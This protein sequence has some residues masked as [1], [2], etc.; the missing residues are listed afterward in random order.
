MR[1][2]Y[3]LCVTVICLLLTGIFALAENA[4]DK[5]HLDL[6]SVVSE[7][8]MLVTQFV[9]T[10]P[11]TARVELKRKG[12]RSEITVSPASNSPDGKATATLT[13]CAVVSHTGGDWETHLF[14]ITTETGH[15]GGPGSG[16]INRKTN[17]KDILSLTAKAGDY[18]MGELLELGVFAGTP[19]TLMVR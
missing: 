17:L 7:D 12:E 11:K 18:R 13:I 10:V 9:I 1:R 6:K 5:Y 2:S 3:A 19:I 8:T 4:A 15:V 16:T 14:K